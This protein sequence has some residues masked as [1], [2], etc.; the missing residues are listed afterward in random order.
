MTRQIQIQN[1][2]EILLYACWAPIMGMG[3][4]LELISG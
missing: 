1:F 2:I 4:L 3:N